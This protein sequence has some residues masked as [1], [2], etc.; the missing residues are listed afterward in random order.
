MTANLRK[1]AEAGQTCPCCGSIVSVYSGSDGT[2][3]YVPLPS[4]ALL[5]VVEAAETI[6][7]YIEDRHKDGPSVVRLAEALARLEGLA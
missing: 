2:N 7:G 3:S 6:F 4:L 5:D 1:I